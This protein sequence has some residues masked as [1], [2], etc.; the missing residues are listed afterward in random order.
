MILAEN[1]LLLSHMAQSAVHHRA[2]WWKPSALPGWL[3]SLSL[4]FIK[5]ASSLKQRTQNV[6]TSR[7]PLRVK[8]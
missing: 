6:A 2:G 3:S 7:T 5:V 1:T 4:M 8:G